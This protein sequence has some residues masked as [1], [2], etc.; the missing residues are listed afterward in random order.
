LVEEC[1]VLADELEE[2]VRLVSLVGYVGVDGG[3]I[4][5]VVGVMM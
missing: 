3:F 1:R 2:L 4:R 5:L